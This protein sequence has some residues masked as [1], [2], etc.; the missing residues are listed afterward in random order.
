[1]SYGTKCGVDLLIKHEVKPIALS[2]NE[3]HTLSAIN[4]V[5]I[6]NTEC[7][8]QADCWLFQVYILHSAI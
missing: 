5:K 6:N 1:M 3:T 4:H 2:R 7:L 8:A